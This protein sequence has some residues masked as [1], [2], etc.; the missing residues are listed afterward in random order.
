MEEQKLRELFHRLSVHDKIAQTIQLNG[1]LFVESGVM[2][3]GPAKDLGFQKEPNFYEIG[4][5]Y[6][7]NDHQKLY[8][9]QKD[10][11]ENSSHKIP[12]L[13][14]SDIVYGFRTIF[15]MPLAQAGSYDFD[16]IQQAAEISAKESYLNGI[17]VVFSPMLD[18]VRDPRWGRVMESPGEDVYTSKEFAKRVV[19]GYQGEK[20]DYLQENHVAACIKHFAAYGAPEGGREY[21]QVEL[22]NQKLFNEYLQPYEAAVEANCELVMTAFNLLNGVPS[23]GNKWL[24]R[25]I[26]RERFGFNGVLVSDYAAVQ[27]LVS[28]GFAKD[29]QDAAKKALE[30]GVDFDMMTAVYANALPELAKDRAFAELLDEA[31]WR[32][33]ILKNK[34]GLFEQPFRGLTEPNT[35]EVLTDEAKEV[36]TKLVE[37]SCVLLKNETALPLKKT[38]DQR[39]AVIGPYAESHFTLGFWASVSGRSSDVLTLKAGLLEQFGQDQLLF[40]RGFNLYEDYSSFGPLKA[41]FEQ[42][43]GPIEDEKF[44]L[45]QS[46][47]QAKKADVI[48]LTIGENFLESGEGASK[49]NLRLPEKQIRLI[50]KLAELKKP[51]VGLLYT[52]RPLVLTEVE[53]YFDSLLLVWFPGVMGGR[54]ICNLLVGEASPSA[55]LTMTFPRS[56]GQIPIYSAQTSTG[57]PLG[58]NA[59]SERFVSKYIDEMNEPLFSF[60]SGKSYADFEGAWQGVEEKTDG[61]HCCYEIANQ[62]EREAWVTPQIYLL[63]HPAEIVRPMKR[64]IATQHLLLAAKERK[65]VTFTLSEE[66]FAYFDN[67]G[68]RHLTSGNYTLQL[69]LLGIKN[70]QTF[71]LVKG[72]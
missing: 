8:Q 41:G 65:V 38:K 52:G 39:I 15:P 68:V 57:R 60:G 53:S 26:L 34:L 10:V 54:G 32:I 55:R 3:T 46:L 71:H 43:N 49:T 19:T 42:L 44:L 25:E 2:N 59:H 5:I 48:L 18:L 9:I 30:A 37:K 11:L 50:K 62:S 24:N 63:N 66:E 13:F 28:H 6:N 29:E 33:L 7:V 47:E 45:E 61:I 31:V 64:L 21:Q 12:L 20:A 23:T 4:S 27:E 40:S 56:E 14:M 35:G 58:E 70:N 72:E 69:D 36:A 51:I 1:D 22:S 16:L 17:H 67:E